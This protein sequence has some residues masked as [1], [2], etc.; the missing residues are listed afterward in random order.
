MLLTLPPQG[1]RAASSVLWR[2]A[3]KAPQLPRARA[4][5]QA[6]IS[7]SSAVQ[8]KNLAMTS[9]EVVTQRIR[10]TGLLYVDFVFALLRS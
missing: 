8:V 9:V 4:R 7:F 5:S 3:L 10:A 2:L 1:A 6:G